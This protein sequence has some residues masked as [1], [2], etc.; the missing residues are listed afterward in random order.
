MKFNKVLGELKE[1]LREDT[2]NKYLPRNPIR[3]F[4]LKEFFE[5][6][7]G[8]V[9]EIEPRNLLEIGCG[10]GIVSFFLRERLPAVEVIAG[11]FDAMALEVATALL[12]PNFIVRFDGRAVPFKDKS[13]DLAM[14]IEVIEHLREPEKMVKELERVSRKAIIISVPEMPFYQLSN[15]LLLKNLRRFGEHKGHLVKFNRGR[16]FSLIKRHIPE[17]SDIEI[18]RSFPWLIARVRIHSI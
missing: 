12:G 7:E 3:Q 2:R 15:L 4:L 17:G 10:E 14:A 11:D 9:K 8:L 1:R 16:L 18:H 5:K 13:F 6:L